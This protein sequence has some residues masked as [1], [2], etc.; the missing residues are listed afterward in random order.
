MVSTPKENITTIHA[1]LGLP[2]N[3]TLQEVF[4]AFDEAKE[5]PHTNPWHIKEVERLLLDVNPDGRAN[6]HD[7]FSSQSAAENTTRVDGCFCVIGSKRLCDD[8]IFDEGSLGAC[9]AMVEFATVAKARSADVQQQIHCHALPF[10]TGDRTGT[11]CLG[12]R[13]RGECHCRHRLQV[14]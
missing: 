14:V 3:A 5:N 1:L 9:W 2:D 13:R 10:Q 4:A 6:V 8:G 7:L 11:V 12:N